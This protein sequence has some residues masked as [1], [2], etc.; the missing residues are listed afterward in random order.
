MVECL[1][2][3][4]M[5]GRLGCCGLKNTATVGRPGG[6]IVKMQTM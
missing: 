3:G 5:M 6:L 2:K 1:E 4:G